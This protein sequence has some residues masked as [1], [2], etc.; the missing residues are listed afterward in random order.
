M[1]DRNIIF[2]LIAVIFLAGIF[3]QFLRSDIIFLMNEKTEAVKVFNNFKTE[4][5]NKGFISNE[6][7]MLIYDESEPNSTLIKE[8]IART[9][10]YMK[11][12]L[13]VVD[14]KDFKGLKDSYRNVII[15]FEALNKFPSVNEI[16]SFANSGGKILFAERALDNEGFFRISGDLGIEETKS[17]V[18]LKGISLKSNVLIKA[19]GFS[20]KGDFMVNSS[21]DVKLKSRCNLLAVSEENKPLLWDIPYGNGK[22]MFFNGSTLNT[23]NSRGMIIGMLGILNEEFI[24]PVINI[25]VTFIDDFPAPFP[26]GINEK[27]YNEY[28]VDTPDFYRYIWWPDILKGAKNYNLKYTGMVIEQYNRLVNG[29]FEKASKDQKISF[30][31]YGRELVKSGGEIGIHGYNHQPLALDGHIKEDL[32][33]KPWNRESDMFDSINEVNKYARGVF[34][35]YD[36]TSYVPPSNILSYEGRSAILKAMPK[37]KVL[38]SVYANNDYG[39]AYEQEFSISK[40][41]ITELPRITFG[42]EV[43]SE[44]LWDAYNGLTSLGVFSH[45]I[46]PDDVLDSKRNHGKSWKEMNVEYSSLIKLVKDD[47]GWVRPFTATEGA[48]ELLKFDRCYPNFNFNNGQISGECKNFSKDQYFILRTK[49]NPTK[50]KNCSTYKIDEGVYLV[51][52]QKPDFSIR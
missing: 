1:R 22:I 46:H 47:F 43:N 28:K 37:L 19:K 7:Y 14:I 8:N 52:A 17:M 5:S 40:D 23:K 4:S 49:K 2:V 25:K 39:D 50:F 3:V 38:S 18:I 35:G 29:P 48:I 20:I 26:S 45:F 16:L 31:E 36:F 27:I 6:R 34:P 10:E 9:F 30:L 13:D 21:L 12:R 51:C 24:Y 42:Y 15:A 44:V 41:G 11:K 33:Y 32:G